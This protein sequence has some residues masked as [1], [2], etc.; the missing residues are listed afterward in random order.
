MLIKSIYLKVLITAVTLSSSITAVADETKF[1][2]AVV[3]KEFGFNSSKVLAFN[4]NMRSCAEL[5]IA[6]KT[7][8]SEVACTA[9]IT[10]L[11]LV[12]TDTKKAKY[13]AS[14]TYS[15]RGISRYVNND[16]TGAKDD[17]IIATRIDA[18]SIT[19]N[20]LKLINSFLANDNS[21]DKPTSIAD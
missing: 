21:L 18:N 14:L 15:N 19:Q 10:S 7:D 13:L 2:I 3:K 6:Q 9:A 12:K 16:L 17:L 4:K 8:E 1:K 11:K 5:T 20:N